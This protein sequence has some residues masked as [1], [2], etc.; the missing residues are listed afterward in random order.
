MLFFNALS[1]TQI[2]ILTKRIDFKTKTR[3]SIISAVASGIVGIA[4]ALY[5]LGVWSLVGQIVSKQFLYTLCLWFINRWYP[6][7]RFS[8][9]SFMYMWN[10]GWKIL[11]SGLLNNIW[12]QLYQVVV[13]KYYSPATLG[14]Y[15]RSNQFASLFSDNFTT[16]I[17]RVSFPILANIQDDTERLMLAYKK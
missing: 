15:T 4:M 8:L 6:T 2:T 9:N 12:N 1:I 16:I 5:G 7:F 17:Q 14:Q 11:A 3:A 13:G 10:F